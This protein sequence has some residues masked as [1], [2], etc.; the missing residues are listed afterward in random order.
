MAHQLFATRLHG[1]LVLDMCWDCHAIWFDRH[2]S[3]Q[4]APGA[5]LDL[6]R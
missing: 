2:E 6:F 1:E 3:A 5:V 4:L